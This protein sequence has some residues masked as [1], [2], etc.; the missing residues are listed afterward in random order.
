MKVVQSMGFQVIWIS[1]HAIQFPNPTLYWIIIYSMT[2]TQSQRK[3]SVSRIRWCLVS[4]YSFL[5]WTLSTVTM[6]SVLPILL[7]VCIVIIIQKC[8]PV[9][10]TLITLNFQ[11]LSQNEN[12]STKDMQICKKYDALLH[13]NSPTRSEHIMSVQ[14]MR[15]YIHLAKCLKPRL[16]Q[17]ASDVIAK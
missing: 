11:P 9:K 13:G 6:I 8:K 14:F 2:S 1:I 12:E 17:E 3:I 15:K 16:T 5:C 4:I 7:F 10:C